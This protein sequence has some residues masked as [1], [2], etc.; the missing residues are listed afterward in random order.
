[1][2]KN[3]FTLIELMVVIAIVG[4][5]SSVAIVSYKS[6]IRK[7]YVESSAL[8]FES[9]LKFMVSN[10]KKSAIGENSLKYIVGG[11]SLKTYSNLS[12]NDSLLS[13]QRLS[14]GLY[15]T[16]I[17]KGCSSCSECGVTDIKNLWKSGC[18]DVKNTIG[19]PLPEGCVTIQNKNISNGY[20]IAVVKR[21]NDVRIL[22][23][24]NAPGTTTW[25]EQ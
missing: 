2:R 4:I 7:A 13:T 8:Q 16:V 19:S 23:Y 21:A 18:I 12:C 1:M 25:I 10:N 9:A 14:T 17:K 24:V 11:D 6:S 20:K 22:R 15:E 5:L 3:G